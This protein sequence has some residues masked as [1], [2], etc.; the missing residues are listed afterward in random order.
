MHRCQKKL[1]CQRK[2]SYFFIAVS[3]KWKFKRTFV[4]QVGEMTQWAEHKLCMQ[5][6]Y[7]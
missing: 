7:I 5:G 6:S 3:Y 1:S 4:Y 2:T